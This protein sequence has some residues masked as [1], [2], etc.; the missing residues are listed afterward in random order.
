M[1]A[2]FAPH[3]AEELWRKLGHVVRAGWGFVRNPGPVRSV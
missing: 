3:L 2:P 1:L